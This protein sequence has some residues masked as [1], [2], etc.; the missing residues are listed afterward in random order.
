[1]TDERLAELHRMAEL[2]QLLAGVAHEVSTPVSSILSNNQVLAKSIEK[3][4]AALGESPDAPGVARAK[5]IAVT[6]QSLADVDRVACERI[7]ALVRSLKTVARAGDTELH[8]IDLNENIAS[9]LKLT[10]AEF[11]GR[12][13][14][15]TEF[16]ALPEIDCHPHLINQVFLNLLMNAAQAIEGNGKIRV[17]TRL[18]GG[19]AVVSISD[20]GHGIS[21][22]DKPKVLNRG[23]T[24]KP[25]GVGTGLGLTIVKQIVTE[26]HGGT[27]G[28]ESEVGKGTTFHVR[29]PVERKKKGA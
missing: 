28:F 11:R 16:G 18:D 10:Q 24:T 23:F 25:V 21:D 6:M 2:G 9:A 5:A 29:L 8:K 19:D 20:T 14:V 7:G 27:I 12:V 26:R 4:E 17:S 3:L 15:E 1:M 13:E 22:E